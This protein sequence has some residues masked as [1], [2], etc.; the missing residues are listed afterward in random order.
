MNPDGTITLPALPAQPLVLCNAAF[1]HTLSV[2]EREVAAIA[3]TDAQAQQSASNLLQRLTSA[4]SAL[5]KARTELKAPLLAKGREIDTA[6]QAPAKRIEEAKTAIRKKVGA[7]Q[8]AQAE[9]AAQAEKARL[10]EVAR[11][12]ALARAEQEAADAKAEELARIAREA[13]AKA[14]PAPAGMVLEC[15]DFDDGEPSAPPPKTET[16]LKL[17]AVKYAAPVVAPK[18]VGVATKVYLVIDKVD[19]AKLPDVFVTREPKLAAIRATYTV[20]WKD[21]DPMPECSGVTFK[22][23]RQIVSTGRNVF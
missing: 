2:V 7:F 15:A 5:E 3:I 9:L 10:A 12:E 19:A 8:Q 18:A 17:E 11:L 22:I 23:D 20:G 6:A 4:G 21:G 14:P 1:L 13:A 16:E